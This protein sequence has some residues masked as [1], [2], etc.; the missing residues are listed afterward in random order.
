MAPHISRQPLAFPNLQHSRLVP[1]GTTKG[2]SQ[3]GAAVAAAL[4]Y[5]DVSDI[6]MSAVTQIVGG[7]NGISGH[8][9]M[10]LYYFNILSSDPR[11]MS[12][13]HFEDLLRLTEGTRLKLFVEKGAAKNVNEWWTS[14]FQ[15]TISAQPSG[16]TTQRINAKQYY[17]L[18]DIQLLKTTH[19][20]NIMLGL[21]SAE[22]LQ[23]ELF[24]R[25]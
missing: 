25:H 5:R 24:N 6:D 13:L 4:T 22:K 21:L 2:T 8:F 15:D 12:R 10:M 17:C 14:S 1:A 3:I 18:F 7:F 23:S 16:F 20:S 11:L 9:R 19:H